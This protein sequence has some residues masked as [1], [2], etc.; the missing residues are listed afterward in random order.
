M[1]ILSSNLC[2]FVPSGFF[3][4]GWPH[5]TISSAK[6][7]S[8]YFLLKAYS[9]INIS[10]LF[11][12]VADWIDANILWFPSDSFLMGMLQ[13][14]DAVQLEAGRRDGTADNDEEEDNDRRRVACPHA[15]CRVVTKERERTDRRYRLPH[16]WLHI[17]GREPRGKGM[18]SSH[19][20]TV[21]G[22]WYALPGAPQLASY[23]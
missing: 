15:E 7:W 12:H 1:L 4:P 18:N 13:G 2:P 11:P 16:N 5:Q 14:K 19:C 17:C 3:L 20:L 22:D 21:W 10:W 8:P 9:G 23:V 6:T